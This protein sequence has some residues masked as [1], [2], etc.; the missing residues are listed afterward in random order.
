MGGVDPCHWEVVFL[1]SYFN[2]PPTLETRGPWH[3]INAPAHRSRSVQDEQWKLQRH[4][5]HVEQHKR[6][7]WDVE[8]VS[9]A[10]NKRPNLSK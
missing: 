9:I 5:D 1:S 7:L 3:P 10:S 8:D 6:G 2:E 4:V